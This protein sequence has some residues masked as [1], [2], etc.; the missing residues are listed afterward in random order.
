[1]GSCCLAT[2]RRGHVPSIATLE[3]F[4]ILQNG[5][6]SLIARDHQFSS[7]LNVLNVKSIG[8]INT[9]QRWVFLNFT[10]PC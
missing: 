5:W 8:D 3:Y 1:M 4:T 10:F 7:I 2:F 6:I 9:D